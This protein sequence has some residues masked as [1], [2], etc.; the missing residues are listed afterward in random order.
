MNIHWILSKVFAAS[1]EIIMWFLS[2]IL[3]IWILIYTCWSI[4]AVLEWNWLTCGIDL[5]NVLLNSVYKYFIENFCV[6]VPQANN[7][8]IFF[9]FIVMPLSG[10]DIR[11]YWFHGMSLVVFLPFLFC[12]I[13]W[14]VLVRVL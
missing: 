2:C 9:S 6:Y 14:G 10:F 3:F 7:S 1:I 11:V 5:F 8:V 12:G 13:V 4:L